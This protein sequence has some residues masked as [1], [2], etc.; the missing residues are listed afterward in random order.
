VRNIGQSRVH[1]VEITGGT[2]PGVGGSVS[3]I[4]TSESGPNRVA[5]FELNVFRGVP[6]R[7][8]RATVRMTGTRTGVDGNYHFSPSTIEITEGGFTRSIT[9]PPG[10]DC[11][12]GDEPAFRMTDG[13]AIVLNPDVNR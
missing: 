13:G 6:P 8:H 5:E 10:M 9:V 11:G 7:P 12:R 1:H 3:T 2:T 4:A